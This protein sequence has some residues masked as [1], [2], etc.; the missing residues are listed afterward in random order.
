[1][2]SRQKESGLCGGGP[3]GGGSPSVEDGKREKRV[4]E[5][6]CWGK[7][8]ST[9]LGRQRPIEKKEGTSGKGGEN[10][11]SKLR[12]SVKRDPELVGKKGAKTSS[13]TPKRHPNA[14]L[15]AKPRE[16]GIAA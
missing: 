10:T 2:S 9:R 4:R 7:A 16:K 1:V 12:Y 14:D 8:P 6:G 3:G 11:V 5:N 15:R 13:K